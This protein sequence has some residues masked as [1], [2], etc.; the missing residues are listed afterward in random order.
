MSFGKTGWDAVDDFDKPKPKA[1]SA[2][3]FWMPPN[4]TKRIIFLDTDPF[5]FFEH[6]LWALAKTQ[7]KEICLKKNKLADECPACDAEMWPSYT[8]YLSVV[9]MGDVT[10]KEDGEVELRGFVSDK[11]INYQFGRKLFG[12]KRGGRDKPGVLLKIQREAAK[13]KGL[14]GTVWDV[15]RSGAKTEGIGDDFTFVEK[16][17]KKNIGKYLLDLGASEE[18]LETDPF[19]YKEVFV[20][21][22]LETFQ[23]YFKGSG[24]P[25]TE[26]DLSTQVENVVIEDDDSDEPPFDM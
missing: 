14:I 6:N 5:C 8:G 17:P 1:N 24:S 26:E 21:T 23:K 3:R 25:V 19:D 20:P 18:F 16:I 15:Y 11:G 7:H 12:A 10:L 22:P 4:V 13:R 2:K 9:D